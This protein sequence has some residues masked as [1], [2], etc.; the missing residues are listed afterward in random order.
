[1][2]NL[3]GVLLPEPAAEAIPPKNLLIRVTYLRHG[4]ELKSVFFPGG[5]RTFWSNSEPGIF[6]HPLQHCFL[7]R[8]ARN[9]DIA[10]CILLFAL[11]ASLISYFAIDQYFKFTIIS[12]R[13]GVPKFLNIATHYRAPLQSRCIDFF[14]QTYLISEEK[15]SKNTSLIC[16]FIYFTC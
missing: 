9:A 16:H 7:F 11:R 2:N 3:V 6:L 10:V 1:M 8:M 12:S 4:R 13:W 15:T 5:Q 14:L